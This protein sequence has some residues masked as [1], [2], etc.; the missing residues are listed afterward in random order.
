MDD[1]KRQQLLNEAMMDKLKA[2]YE[3][4]S[5]IPEI[6]TRLSHVEETV[7]TIER[8]VSVVKLVVT[9]HSEQLKKMAS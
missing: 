1:A 4:V 7:D 3:L 5:D 6:K 9:D 8:D 2:I